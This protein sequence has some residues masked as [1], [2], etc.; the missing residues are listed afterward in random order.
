MVKLIKTV[1]DEDIIAEYEQENNKLTNAVKIVITPQGI[2]MMPFSPFSKEKSVI[3]KDQHIMYV[4]DPED[5]ILNAYNAQFGGIVIPGN[6][7]L[8][9]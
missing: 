6:S 8:I 2:G 4:T 5:E 3:L 1:T 9:I 7:K